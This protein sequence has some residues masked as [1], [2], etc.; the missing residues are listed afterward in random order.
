MRRTLTTAAII[1]LGLS[2]VGPADLHAQG[3]ESSPTIE[4]GSRRIGG[5]GLTK[6]ERRVT[7]QWD[8]PDEYITEE[9]LPKKGS[10]KRLPAL[11]TLLLR[12]HDGQAWK[13]A[14]EKVD[15]II[16]EGGE[17]A[18]ESHPRGKRIAGKA[19]FQ[20]AKVE[21]VTGDYD[22]TEKLLATSEKWT[23]STP[24]HAVLREKMVRENYRKKLAAGDVDG[25][26]SLFNKAQ[27][28]TE[29]EDERIWLGEELSE[30]A[31]VAFET[32]NE[33]E[34][35]ELMAYLQDVAPQNTRYRQLNDKI[36]AGQNVLID[37][38]KLAFLVIGFVI[39]WGAFSKWRAKAKVKSL[40]G[41]DLEEF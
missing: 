22:T 31:W 19:Y 13:D 41:S 30:R 28:M 9:T 36:E 16:E 8:E 21:F 6:S 12:Y 2:L 35:K 29:N 33:I 17:E 23:G 18:I 1:A 39:A 25:A 3:D 10:K 34:M 15:L 26:V 20:C 37:A 11:F 7:E 40:A 32:K 38:A 14:C 5:P 4:L 24:R 27:A